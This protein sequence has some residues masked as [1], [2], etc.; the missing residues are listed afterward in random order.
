MADTYKYRG[1]YDEGEVG[2]IKDFLSEQ[3]DVLND[4]DA[5]QLDSAYYIKKYGIIALGL[6]SVLV[7]IK[8]LP[9]KK[10]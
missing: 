7:I 9:K 3:R 4:E 5:K 10:N 1:I 8:L 6:V 2:R